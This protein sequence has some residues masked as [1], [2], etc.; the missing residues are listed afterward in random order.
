M[1]IKDLMEESVTI[2]YMKQAIV[3]MDTLENDIYKLNEELS[4]Y[5]KRR[6]DI[7]HWLENEYFNDNKLHPTKH[8][9]I[10]K[11]LQDITVH[12]RRIKSEIQILSDFLKNK[13]HLLNENQRRIMLN[14]IDKSLDNE[15]VF[16][17]NTFANIEDLKDEI[18]IVDRR[19]ETNLENDILG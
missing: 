9:Y 12:R 1:K 6:T 19:S 2:K 5:D 13:S 18:N 14:D 17:F 8:F 10:L 4:W 11:E 16:K 3:V 15:L 7:Y